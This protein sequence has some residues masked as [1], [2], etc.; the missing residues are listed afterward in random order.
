MDSTI[1][2]LRTGKKT[3]GAVSIGDRGMGTGKA[4]KNYK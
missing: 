2:A 4:K 3:S 1:V